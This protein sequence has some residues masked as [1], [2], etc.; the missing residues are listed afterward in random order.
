MSDILQ[1]LEERQKT[2]LVSNEKTILVKLIFC[3]KKKKKY[4]M[5]LIAFFH[6]KLCTRVFITLSTN[7][8]YTIKNRVISPEC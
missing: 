1:N 5:W 3:K 2:C 4:E 6:R 7:I 8:R